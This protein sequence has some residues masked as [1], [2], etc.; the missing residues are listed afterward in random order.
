[1]EALLKNKAKHN[2]KSRLEHLWV[3]SLHIHKEQTKNENKVKLIWRA[4]HKWVVI[5][6]HFIQSNFSFF[7]FIISSQKYFVHWFRALVYKNKYYFTKYVSSLWF[8]SHFYFCWKI[9]QFDLWKSSLI[10]SIV[11]HCISLLKT[12]RTKN[13]NEYCF[14]DF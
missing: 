10:S 4:S 5:V 8:E 2:K 1:M 3:P 7:H 14:V 13:P 12:E 9:V 6:H 11:Y